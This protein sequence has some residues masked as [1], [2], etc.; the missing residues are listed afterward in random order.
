MSGVVVRVAHRGP[1]VLRG[2]LLMWLRG[3][4]P[5]L[6]TWVRGARP[7]IL[8]QGTVRIGHRFKADGL[9][10]RIELGALPG[11]ELIVG[12]DVYLNG[13]V[14]AV[15]STRIEIGDHTRIGDHTMLL[16]SDVHEVE[17]GAGVRR[18]P[19]RIGRNV[20]IAR[21]CTILPG[22]EIG[23][24]SVVAAGSVVTRSVPPRTLV[25][26]VPARPIRELRADDDWVRS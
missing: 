12:D 5:G 15:A 14:S 25:A 3:V 10:A 2:T 4:R 24:H 21:N 20:W 26:G 19:V 22:V 13:G 7:R 11:G 18:A 6:L 8:N 17:Q 23:D 16:D 1:L 9:R